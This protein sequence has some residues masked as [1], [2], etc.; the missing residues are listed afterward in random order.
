MIPEYKKIVFAT[1]LSAGAETILRNAIAV[2]R[3]H[4][5]QVEILHVLPDVDQALVNYVSVFMGSEKLAAHEAE[6]K[7]TVA[8]ELSRRLRDFATLE[9]ADHPEDLARI[10]RIEVVHGPP[11]STILS[12][13]KKR[14]ADLLVIGTHGKGRIEYAFLGSIA[15]KIM[16]RSEIPVLLIPLTHS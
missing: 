1:D 11:A 12:E 5:A 6:H 16:R 7:D 8:G 9:L 14:R 15:Q 10:S 13:C 4:Q 2:A 3:A